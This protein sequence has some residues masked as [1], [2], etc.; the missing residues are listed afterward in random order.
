MVISSQMLKQLPK[1]D[2]HRH[3]EGTIRLST[4]REIARDFKLDLPYQDEE[5]F[6]RCLQYVPGQNTF[7]S[8][9]HRELWVTQEVI[10]RVATE[11]IEDAL[12]DGLVYLE[13]RFSTDHYRVIHGHPPH[14]VVET[15][16]DV[17]SRA[18]L[19]TNLIMALSGGHGQTYEYVKPNLDV[20]RE[21]LAAPA[22]PIVGVDISPAQNWF[23]DRALFRQVL[24]ELRAMDRFPITVHAGEGTRA[25]EVRTAVEE[26][27][28]SRIGHG[29]GAYYDT[30]VLDLVVAERVPLEVCL[31][32]NRDTGAIPDLRENPAYKLFGAGA[33]VTLN[34]DDPS[35]SGDLTMTDEYRNALEV[36][37]FSLSDLKAVLRNSIEAAFVSADDREV[38][39]SKASSRWDQVLKAHQVDVE[40][41]RPK[42]VRGSRTS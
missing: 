16:S 24:G 28:A 38:L 29:V 13:L 41:A 21:C 20:L 5:A 7:F 15:L 12:A 10:R 8:C 23:N 42:D 3:L 32:S 11:A 1:V 30:D 25:E 39:W 37:G 22:T 19:K 34:T 18:P 6:R 33:R 9:F 27:G 40:A 35:I 4:A 26:Y 17:V 36:L 2:L 31:T 14:R